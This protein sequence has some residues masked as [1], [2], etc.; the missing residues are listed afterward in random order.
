MGVA[1]AVEDTGFID[2]REQLAP[3]QVK[4]YIEARVATGRVEY[5]NGTIHVRS[6]HPLDE[7]LRRAIIESHHHDSGKRIMTIRDCAFSKMAGRI[8]N[9]VGEGDSGVDAM[10]LFVNV[11]RAMRGLGIPGSRSRPWDLVKLVCFAEPDIEGNFFS[12]ADYSM[13]YGLAMKIQNAFEELDKAVA[14]TRT[15]IKRK[16]KKEKLE[17]TISAMRRAGASLADIEE[18]R[19]SQES[20]K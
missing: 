1:A 6:K 18:F 20:E 8:Y 2:M 11:E 13:L 5:N 12:E 16:I 14:E 17:A 19:K 4:A 10:T 9:G 7:C 3:K 15:E